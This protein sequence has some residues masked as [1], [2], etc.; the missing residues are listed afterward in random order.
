MDI[1]HAQGKVGEATFVR[2]SPGTDLLEGIAEAC[3]LR[4]IRA[5]C[6]AS[7]IASLRRA[8]FLVVVPMDTPT[9]GGYSDPRRIEAPVELVCGQGTVGEE[10][11][12]EVYVHLH[13]ALSDAAGRL[14]G[15]H[16][17][18]GGCPVLITAE[19]VILPLEGARLVRR[20]DARAG[21]PLLKP[22]PPG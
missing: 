7:C 6:I 11:S 4:G 18:P 15:G 5:G 13:A 2:L 14:H 17:I 21:L 3:R 10:E 22:L 19:I 20:A 1:E 8:A 9:G 16:L 12:G